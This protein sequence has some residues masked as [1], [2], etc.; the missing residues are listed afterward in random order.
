MGGERLMSILDERFRDCICL[1]IY[2]R[3]DSMRVLGELI[4]IKGAKSLERR[5]R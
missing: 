4:M 3:T 2:D 1:K 5:I